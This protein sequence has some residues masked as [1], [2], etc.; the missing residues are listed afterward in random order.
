MRLE[1]ALRVPHDGLDGDILLA[2][3]IPLERM[4]LVPPSCRL[5]D[6]EL[7]RRFTLGA[8]VPCGAGGTADGPVRVLHPSGHLLGVA[9]GRRGLLHPRVVLHRD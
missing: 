5:S 6:P 9:D 7:A 2:A 3:L 1:D 4:P 8:A